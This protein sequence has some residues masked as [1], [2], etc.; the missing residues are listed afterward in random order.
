VIA[1]ATTASEKKVNR[2]TAWASDS[3][4]SS[5]INRSS[6]VRRERV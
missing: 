4:S 2:S 1:M 3:R 5:D 6:R